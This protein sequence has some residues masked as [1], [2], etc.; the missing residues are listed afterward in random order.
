LE[1]VLSHFFNDDLDIKWKLLMK[2]KY[3]TKLR[4]T[5]TAK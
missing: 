5:G 4:S 1:S 3:N 2:S